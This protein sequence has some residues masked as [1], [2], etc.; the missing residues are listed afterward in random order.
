[1]VVER[2]TTG[3]RP[4]SVSLITWERLA[5]SGGTK[6]VLGKQLVS[7]VGAEMVEGSKSGTV[8]ALDNLGALLARGSAKTASD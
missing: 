5:E 4:L 3:D 2:V 8:M 7:F 1:M 6:L